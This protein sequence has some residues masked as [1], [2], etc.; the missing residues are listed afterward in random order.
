[1]FFDFYEVD[2]AQKTARVLLMSDDWS[3]KDLQI[4]AI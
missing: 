3:A 4:I 1:M 2:F